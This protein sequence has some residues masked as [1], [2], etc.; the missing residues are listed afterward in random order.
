[1][2]RTL[3]VAAA[4]MA[5]LVLLVAVAPL[6]IDWT[7]IK[8]E[9][10]SRIEAAT[11]RK[12]EIGALRLRLL[13]T[14]AATARHVA[15]ANLAGAQPAVMATVDSLRLKLQFLPLL[16]G[17]VVIDELVLDHPEIH[18][19]RLPGGHGNW[20]FTPDTAAA[21]AKPAAPAAQSKPA[22]DQGGDAAL[23]VQRLRI[24][25]G[26]AT[27]QS[28]DGRPVRVD[29]VELA[30]DLA[31]AN[32]PFASRGRLRLQGAP[33]GIEVFVDAFS[34]DHGTPAHALVSLPEADG[35]IEIK[36]MISQL[37]TGPTLRGA[38]DLSLPSLARLNAGLPALPLGLT[39]TLSASR[40]E[41]SLQD[42]R[43][44]F[45]DAHA[46]GNIVAGLATTPV[47]IDAQLTAEPVD[48][49]AL[50]ARMAPP[51]PSAGKTLAAPA[52][53]SQGP[54][55]ASA[56]PPGKSAQPPTGI[57]AHV[58]L[59]ADKVTWHGVTAA[60]RTEAI[61]DDGRLTINRASARLPGDAELV[62]A[63]EIGAGPSF[64]GNFK[65]A[66]ADL[67][68]LLRANGV[69]VA[70]VPPERLRRFALA[71]RIGGG[72]DEVRI[73]DLDGTIDATRLRGGATVRLGAR[74][75][76]GLS[77]AADRIDVD[78]YRGRTDPKAP[79]P[80]APAAQEAPA[81][82]A[83]PKST[84]ASPLPAVAPLAALAGFDAAVRL[85]VGEVLA[86]GVSASAVDA[87]A[88]LSD[89]TLALKSLSIGDVGGGSARMAGTLAGLGS[90]TPSVQGA[91]IEA[92]SPQPARLLRLFGAKP[93]AG[94]DQMGPAS[95]SATLDGDWSAVVLRARLSAFGLDANAEGRLSQPLLMPH[96]DL[97]LTA[98]HDSAAQLVRLF[99]P[100]Y[101][102]RGTLGAF[103]ASARVGGDKGGL[104]LSALSAK[105][106]TAEVTGHARVGFGA[107]TTV[108]AELV[109][110]DLDLDPFLPAERSG[111]LMLPLPG[112]R[113]PGGLV[114]GPATAMVP[115]AVQAGGP[116]SREPLDLSVLDGL[117]GRLELSAKSISAQGWRLDIP[118]AKL[119]ASEG[120]A[121]LDSLNGRLLGGTIAATARLSARGTAGQLSVAGAELKDIKLGL[122][123][124]QVS[125]GRVD[126]EARWTAA[127]R[128]PWDLVST[129]A[130]DGK[131]AVRDGLLTGFDLPAVNQRLQHLDTIG[132]VLSLAQAAMAGGTTRFSSLTGTFHADKGVVT[133]RDIRLEAEGGNATAETVTD[134]P[135]YT[136][137]TRLAVRVADGSSPP[138]VLKLD[139]PIDNPRK[140]A[141]ANDLQRWL[142]DR[143]LG[144]ALGAKGGG[145]VEALTG[146]K[147]KDQPADQQQQPADDQKT[148][149]PS[150]LLKNLLKGL[151]R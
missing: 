67:R 41:L 89:G 99:A 69:E 48:L 78:S 36:G 120:T 42:L 59:A 119:A 71:G 15:L 21:P 88:T 26:V 9:V 49:D 74:P 90:L 53:P 111:G 4:A 103:T 25:E 121:T 45:A 65:A 125:R 44:A 24:T 91:A 66:A 60:V 144:K 115:V 108:A 22:R 82:A 43:L 123:A 1:M 146:R 140:I 129:L 116:W 102:P 8:G 107:R 110:G 58:E 133:S 51:A 136:T 64:D 68:A 72:G 63:G 85:K 29:G 2:K 143:G 127:G 76:Y 39:G 54:A 23:P 17:R 139:G 131:L 142:M 12:V 137:D 16:S 6:M 13:P 31:S 84:Q 20:E 118:Q 80:A 150:G 35:H 117:E 134:L 92:A 147:P 79:P 11:G 34:K 149:K 55:V 18:L 83:G 30:M 75:S 10:R 122:G 148:Q 130:G 14:P 86:N 100:S 70:H 28:G 151:G 19:Q 113:G 46:S 132:N 61:L 77:L 37:S 93:P 138:L 126:G 94:M 95:L 141:D 101:R 104:E 50:L 3:I 33:I 97:Q 47:L 98:H 112:W 56:Q 57:A 105:A 128:S 106:G 87:D 7:A 73:T 62:V 135:R 40:D 109:A 32:G 5:A 145:L 81:P 52:S 38:L 96:Y 114:P 27:Y 124:L